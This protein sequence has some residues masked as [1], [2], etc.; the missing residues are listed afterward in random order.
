[1]AAA[2]AAEARGDNEQR[3]KQLEAALALVPEFSAAQWH[4]ARVR[5]G[6]EWLSLAEAEQKTAADPRL[7]EYRELR[8]AAEN[9]TLLRNLA[10]WCARTGWDDRARLHYA[11]L[12]THGDANG[13]SRQEAIKNLDL[14]YVGGSWVSGEDLAIQK[15]EAAAADLALRKLRPRIERLQEAIDGGSYVQ[16][17][18]AIEQLKA[19]REP[20]VIPVLESFLGNAGDEFQIQAVRRLAT[21]PHYAATKALV[22]FAVLPESVVVRDE[23]TKALKKRP[24]YEYVPVLLDGL[25]AT[26]ESQYEVQKLPDGHIVHRHVLIRE[27]PERKDVAIANL[28][29][30]PV[31]V[32][33]GAG[34]FGRRREILRLNGSGRIK[35]IIFDDSTQLKQ[36]RIASEAESRSELVQALANVQD[37]GQNRRIFKA[38]AATTEQSIS[39]KP[40]S[41][42]NWWDS[43][44]EY[45]W[46]K[47][48]YYAY[49]TETSQYYSPPPV[50]IVRKGSC[51]FAGTLVRTETGLATIESLQPGDRVLS[52]DQDTGELAYRVVLRKTLRSPAPMVRLTSGGETLL[53][54]LGHPFWVSGQGWKMAKQLAEGEL[55]HTLSGSV[56]I[57]VAAPLEGKFQAHN[58]V[59]DDFSTY[60]VGQ[61]GL[62]VHDNEFRKPTRAV[63][64]GY[65]AEE[66]SLAAK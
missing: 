1:V 5:L 39:E 46:P 15:E 38:L 60:F 51:F 50:Q 40:S 8:T 58:L 26:I 57:E 14:H 20:E 34:E 59:V 18:R 63:L 6:E 64:P 44:N 28:I 53:T 35:A 62:L 33:R 16:R 25:S 54:T 66:E 55:L 30:A 19:F 48:T 45:E 42:W 32:A 3:G 61:A 2:L 11:Q 37:Q 29:A 36:E 21:F 47:P 22:Q 17:E 41:W 7:A 4:L 43:H 56:P 27:T 13:D 31:W 49:T 12:L 9:S 10:R 65:I 52:Q 23:A 24:M